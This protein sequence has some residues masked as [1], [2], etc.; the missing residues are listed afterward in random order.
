MYE[1]YSTLA[2]IKLKHIAILIHL[3]HQVK[4]KLLRHSKLITF[5]LRAKWLIMNHGSHKQILGE[6]RRGN[7]TPKMTFAPPSLISL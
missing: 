3:F 2:K 4:N 6:A 5:F 1:N 7:A